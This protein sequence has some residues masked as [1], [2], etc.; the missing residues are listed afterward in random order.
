VAALSN[1][2]KKQHIMITPKHHLLVIYFF[3]WFSRIAIA[4]HFKKVVF[5]HQ[6]LTI[7]KPVLLI[8]NHFSWWDGFIAN[9]INQKLLH[10]KFH[11]LMLEEELK[12]R[13]LFNY[14][15]AFSIKKNSRSIIDS[16]NFCKN[17]LI[18]PTHLLVFYPQGKIVSGNASN[19]K[20][21]KGI[22]KL[23]HDLK[24]KITVI[25]YCARTDYFSAP[26]PTLYLYLEECRLNEDKIIIEE[27][28]QAFY[29]QSTAIQS[30]LT[31]S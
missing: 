27:K 28:Y 1:K 9:Y 30:Q 4:L 19:I 21:E 25:F 11:I 15:G 6:N 3:R 14:T 12:Q 22:D 7:D 8:G 26:K 31:T 24:E 16:L 18:N 23:I 10:K 5:K 29:N 13:I 2:S 20:F 17:I